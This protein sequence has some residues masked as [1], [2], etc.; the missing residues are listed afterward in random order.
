MHLEYSVIDPTKN[1]TLLVTSPV[2]RDRQA[3]TASWLLAR[4][5]Q[6]EQVAFLE[7]SPSG[8]K[9][10][11]MMGG[12]FCGNATMAYGAWL[13][14]GEGLNYGETADLLLEVSGVRESVPCSVTAL[15][16]CYLGTVTMPLPE[17]VETVDFDGRP[18]PVAFLPG[19]CH[20]IAPAHSIPVSEAEALLRRWSAQLPGEAAGLLLLDEE[21]MSMKP[22]VYVKPTDSLV[23]ENGCGSGSAAVGAY[24]TEKCAAPQCVSLRQ[25][26]GTIN[27][28]TTVSDG[29]IASLTITG[30][31]YVK[32]HR[33]ADM[34]TE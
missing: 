25:P 32:D 27:I 8:G 33:T 11:Q 22:L 18:L 34:P 20:I 23:W 21:S 28:V 24:L 12:E 2:P 17:K 4:E 14:D 9:R 6:A 10:M 7:F 1:I 31:V 13:C 26:G 30:V 3:A 19:I 5:E 29:R 15:P 16:D